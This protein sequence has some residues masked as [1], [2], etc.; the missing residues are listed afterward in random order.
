METSWGTG[1]LQPIEGLLTLTDHC[2]SWCV[3]KGKVQMGDR[4][5]G[6]VEIENV[7]SVLS[8][9]RL[10]LSGSMRLGRAFF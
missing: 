5:S 7:F 6:Y 10:K 1:S 3:W 9:N 8:N 2:G 4:V